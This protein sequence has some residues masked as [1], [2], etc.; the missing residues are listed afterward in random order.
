MLSAHHAAAVDIHQL[1]HADAFTLDVQHIIGGEEVSPPL[2][3]SIYIVEFS[4]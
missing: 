4:M 1:N 2:S 3:I